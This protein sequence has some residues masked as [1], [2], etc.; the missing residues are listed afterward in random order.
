MWSCISISINGDDDVQAS[1]KAI[2][3][4]LERNDGRPTG[5]RRSIA[6]PFGSHWVLIARGPLPTAQHSRPGAAHREVYVHC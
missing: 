2:R 5:R 4:W 3:T 6:D 1:S